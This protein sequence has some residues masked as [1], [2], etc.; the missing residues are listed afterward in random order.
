[1]A[2]L[3]TLDKSLDFGGCACRM[4]LAGSCNLP[5]P[6]QVEHVVFVKHFTFVAPSPAIEQEPGPPI[7]GLLTN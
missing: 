5:I 6:A 7:K 3:W 1:M 2:Y 4:A